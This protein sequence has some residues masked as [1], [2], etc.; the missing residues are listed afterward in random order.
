MQ[1]EE[2]TALARENMKKARS[3]S[4]IVMPETELLSQDRTCCCCFQHMKASF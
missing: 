2:M 3:A 4:M 1:L